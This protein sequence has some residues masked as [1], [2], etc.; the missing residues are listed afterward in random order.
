MSLALR[1]LL[2]IFSVGFVYFVLKRIHNGS[3][4]AFRIPFSGF[5]FRFSC[6]S[7]RFLSGRLRLAWRSSWA[8][9]QPGEFRLSGF[10]LLR[11]YKKFSAAVREASSNLEDKI[12]KLSYEEAKRRMQEQEV[13]GAQNGAG[14]ERMKERRYEKMKV[15]VLTYH[16]ANNYGTCLQCYALM[17]LVEQAATIAM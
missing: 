16:S 4:C 14:Y 2:M 11:F 9:H 10:H 12:N 3:S 17:H 5:Y 1:I 13:E 8:V 15:G 6:L 7:W